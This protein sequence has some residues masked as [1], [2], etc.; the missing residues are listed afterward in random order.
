MDDVFSYKTNEEEDYYSILGCDPLSTVIVFDS[1][2]KQAQVRPFSEAEHC[3]MSL[4]KKN[5]GGYAEAVE[6]FFFHL[7]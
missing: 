1:L 3:R 4:K 5:V 2:R 6:R 7:K